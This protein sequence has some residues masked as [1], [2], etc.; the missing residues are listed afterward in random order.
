[1]WAFLGEF[2]M[3]FLVAGLVVLLAMILLF[4][5]LPFLLLRALVDRL[6]GGQ[7]I[8]ERALAVRVRE[9]LDVL[10]TMSPAELEA[11]PNHD[12]TRLTTIAGRRATLSWGT[13]AD[14][15]EG[16]MEVVLDVDLKVFNTRFSPSTSVCHG[17][18]ITRDGERVDLPPEE[19]ARH[20]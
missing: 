7:G 19:L 6:S 16:A 8:V 17:F 14:V 20:D 10:K 12:G 11:H 15:E 3:V 2:A 18:K 5:F 13:S 9:E 4:W 1:M